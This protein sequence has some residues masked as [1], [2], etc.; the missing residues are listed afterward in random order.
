MRVTMKMVGKGLME[1]EP[2]AWPNIIPYCQCILRILPMRVLGGRSPYE[3]VTGLKPKLPTALVAKFPVQEVSVDEYAAGLVE[4]LREAYQRVQALMQDVANAHEEAAPG[5]LSRELK[6][7]DL[8]LRRRN[9]KQVTDVAGAS[10]ARFVRTTDRVIYRVSSV[11]ADQ[12]FAYRIC[13]HHAPWRKLHFQQPVSRKVLVKLDMP[14]LEVEPVK[15]LRRLEIFDLETK[16]WHRATLESMALDGRAR[17]RYDER[18]AA[19]EDVDLAG[20]QFRWLLG[21]VVRDFEEAGQEKAELV[22]DVTTG[23]WEQLVSPE[24]PLRRKPL[25][26][27]NNKPFSLDSALGYTVESGEDSR[28]SQQTSYATYGDEGN[29]TRKCRLAGVL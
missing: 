27:L 3:V 13:D 16:K 4:H 21:E 17:L 25:L 1:S 22:Q 18:P 12:A 8:V 2:D 9:A 15:E 14:E 23:E 28:V 19:T 20:T 5:K 29:T 7:G 26:W 11:V 10:P 24:S 6:I